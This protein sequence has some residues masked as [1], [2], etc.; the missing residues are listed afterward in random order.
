MLQE[1]EVTTRTVGTFLR[2]LREFVEASGLKQSDVARAV[3]MN[4]STVS[5]LFHGGRLPSWA[6]V[7]T[8]LCACEANQQTIMRIE[9]IYE[10]T[11]EAE[12]QRKA[13]RRERQKNIRKASSPQDRL[14]AVVL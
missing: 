3:K 1:I 6:I 8:I 2:Q 4:D 7:F 10:Q 13:R 12:I 11:R 9:G 5:R 14:R